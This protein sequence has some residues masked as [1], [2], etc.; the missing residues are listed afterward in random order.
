MWLQTDKG[1]PDEVD[2]HYAGISLIYDPLGAASGNTTSE[3]CVSQNC[4]APDVR[5]S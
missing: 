2:Q 3:Y 5:L 4:V 1:L